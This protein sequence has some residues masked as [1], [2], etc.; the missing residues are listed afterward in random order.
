MPIYDYECQSCKNVEEI[1]SQKVLTESDE[2]SCSKC[3]QSMKR[4]YSIG[5]PEKEGRDQFSF[6][7]RSWRKGLNTQQQANA[8]LG[9]S[10]R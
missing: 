5:S 10:P 9:D 4:V 3:G 8:L 2:L 1:V 6:G 7:Q